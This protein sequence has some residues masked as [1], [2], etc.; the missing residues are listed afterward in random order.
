MT[1]ST[2]GVGGERLTVEKAVEIIRETVGASLGISI[3]EATA[4]VLSLAEAQ[5]AIRAERRSLEANMRD[6]GLSDHQIREV[7]RQ[8]LGDLD[9]AYTRLARAIS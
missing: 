4:N 5:E 8:V 1:Y 6:K 7:R 2:D 9:K 3:E